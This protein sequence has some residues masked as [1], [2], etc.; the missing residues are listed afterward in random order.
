MILDTYLLL[1][2]LLWDKWDLVVA[3]INFSKVIA[4]PPVF[5][6]YDHISKVL[7]LGGK[8]SRTLHLKDKTTALFGSRIRGDQAFAHILCLGILSVPIHHGC[9]FALKWLWRWFSNVTITHDKVHFLLLDKSS[10]WLVLLKYG[11]RHFSH[12]L[13]ILF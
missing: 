7:E 6:W 1:A 8:L 5:S 10:T 13:N 4:V 2:K 12:I 3:Y 11:V 9:A